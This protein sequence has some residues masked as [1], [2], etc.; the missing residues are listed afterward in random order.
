V[1]YTINCEDYGAKHDL[2]IRR[3]YATVNKMGVT[4]PNS[5]IDPPVVVS[6]NVWP[7]TQYNTTVASGIQDEYRN[8]MPTSLMTIPNYVFPASCAAPSGTATL[9]IRS[10]GDAANAVWFA[11]AGTTSFVAGP[12]MTKATGTATSI[13]VPTTAGTYKLSVVDSQGKKVGESSALLRVK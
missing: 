6:D 11:P 1:K 8:L 2:T 5:T 9:T 10:S 13:A 4:P 3:T 12:T 7:L